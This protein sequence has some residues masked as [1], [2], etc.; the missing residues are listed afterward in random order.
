M[1]KITYSWHYGQKSMFSECSPR[2]NTTVIINKFLNNMSNST[3]HNT[4]IGLFILGFN[5][6][7]SW[8]KIKA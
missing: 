2:E 6:V 4:F 5:R 8:H 3:H 7:N 1:A